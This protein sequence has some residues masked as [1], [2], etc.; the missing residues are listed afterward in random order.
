MRC[1]SNLSVY[2][3]VPRVRE[4]GPLPRQEPCERG[5]DQTDRGQRWRHRGGQ[6]TAQTGEHVANKLHK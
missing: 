3:G 2:L 4:W 5:S 6:L 1:I